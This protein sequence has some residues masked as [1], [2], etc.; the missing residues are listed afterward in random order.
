MSRGNPDEGFAM[1]IDL[2]D[3]LVERVASEAA[4]LVL[5]RVRRSARSPWLT[6]DETARY[7]KCPKSRVYRLVHLRAIPYEKEG[8]RLL[9]D[10]HALDAWVRKGGAGS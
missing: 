9:F 4:Q 2:P 6:V 10:R 1:S 7:L 5:Q 3:D 8:A